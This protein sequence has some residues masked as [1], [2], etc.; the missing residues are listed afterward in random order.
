MYAYIEHYSMNDLLRNITLYLLELSVRHVTYWGRWQYTAL[1]Y[2]V[3]MN[4]FQ[5]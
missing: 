3:Y 5:N 4:N 2:I 1:Y